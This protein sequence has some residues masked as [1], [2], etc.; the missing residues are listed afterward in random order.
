MQLFQVQRKHVSQEIVPGFKQHIPY[1]YYDPL[2]DNG[3]NDVILYV[4]GLNGTISGAD[5]LEHKFFDDKILVSYEKLAHGDNSNSA[6]L[7]A[8]RYV[9]ELMGVINITK[10]KFPNSK[11]FI[12]G[13][14]FGGAI[15]V[16][17]YFKFHKLIDGMIVWNIPY[18]IINVNKTSLLVNLKT[19]CKMLPV[20]FFGI[21]TYDYNAADPIEY[22]TSNKILVRMR[23]LNKENNKK[24]NN[25]SSWTA[26]LIMKK[27][28]KTMNKL[29]KKFPDT[30]F[31]QIQTKEDRLAD[32]KRWNKLNQKFPK[33]KHLVFLEKGWH[34]LCLEEP[35]KDELWN[36]FQTGVIN[37]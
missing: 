33:S 1:V 13:E 37:G 20:I 6:S 34:I 18:K 16:I 31:I 7:H 9:N 3:K 12:A 14:S 35:M 15:S 4:Q 36:I 2:I 8:S 25:K 24:S 23:R 21:T 29:L 5:M 26:N 30:N 32:F 27:S 28:W 10:A 17:F 11:V 22:L 19:A